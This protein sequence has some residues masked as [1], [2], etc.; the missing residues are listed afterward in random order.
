MNNVIFDFGGVI[1]EWEPYRALGD[2][3]VDELEMRSKLSEIGFRRWNLEQDRGRSRGDGLK[4]MERL[5]PENLPIFQAYADGLE[6]SHGNR[7]P[8]TSELVRQLNRDSVPLFGL[9]NAPHGSLEIMKHTAPVIE[10]MRDVVVSADE[11]LVKPDAAIFDICLVGTTLRH[12][13]HCL[14]TTKRRIARRR[15]HFK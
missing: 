10:L 14:S 5:M 8:G 12:P 4:L 1:V 15:N 9:T 2:F 13:K 6:A 3:F 7:V 11:R